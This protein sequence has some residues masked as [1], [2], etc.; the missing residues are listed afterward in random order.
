MTNFECAGSAGKFTSDFWS[1]MSIAS[2]LTTLLTSS[3]P[4]ERNHLPASD[5]ASG[6]CGKTG[7]YSTH[8][9]IPPD[10]VGVTAC[11]VKR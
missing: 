7:I 11:I 2:L 5:L 4:S 9:M 1:S 6:N 10:K 8:G 3:T